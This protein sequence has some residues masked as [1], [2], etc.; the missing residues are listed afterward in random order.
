[1]GVGQSERTERGTTWTSLKALA[2]TL[3][4]TSSGAHVMTANNPEAK[5][6]VA[7]CWDCG[8]G[9]TFRFPEQA[10]NHSGVAEC[11]GCDGWRWVMTKDYTPK[12]LMPWFYYGGGRGPS[13]VFIHDQHR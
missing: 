12:P 2:G 9:M 7:K 1:M 3:T 8:N 10:A 13:P 11:M 6:I 5:P 4:A